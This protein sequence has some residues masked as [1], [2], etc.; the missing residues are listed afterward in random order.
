MGRGPGIQNP[1]LDDSRVRTRT[2]LGSERAGVTQR[3]LDTK[4]AHPSPSPAVH[5]TGEKENT[6]KFRRMP[7]RALKPILNF[8]HV[9]NF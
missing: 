3:C 5:R 6:L 4:V 8:I 1:G 7:L 2:R 9:L